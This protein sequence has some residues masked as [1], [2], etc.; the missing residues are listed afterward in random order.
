MT[1][2]I[3]PLVTLLD[4]LPLAIELAAA[5]V[6]VM[7]P[8]TLLARM[9]ERFKL[10]AS[11]GGRVDR[12]ATLR[13][14][15]DWSWDLLTPTEKAALAQLSVF[16]GGFTLEAAEAVLDLSV[17]STMRPGRST[18]CSRWSTSR[19]C[20]SVRD[21]RFD[22]L[23]SVQEYAAEHLQTAGRYAGSGPRALAS[24]ESRHAA[25]FA[26]LDRAAATAGRCVELENL[27]AP[28][29]ARRRA[30]TCELPPRAGGRLGCVAAARALRGR[31]RTGR[32]GVCRAG[33]E[34]ARARRM[35]SRCW[36]IHW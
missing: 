26:A 36:P 34:R 21:E 20:G 30:A 7:P 24:A 12:Q 6:R 11:T 18:C 29:G 16:E 32:I 19:S 3:E 2:A 23:V 5:R 10:L 4:G 1:A 17:V 28:V 31:R 22:L 9:S 35:R 25:W 8:R 15:F 13:A 33:A 27:V 14:T